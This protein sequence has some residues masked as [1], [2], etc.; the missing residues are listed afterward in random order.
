M[1]NRLTVTEGIYHMGHDV[2]TSGTYATFSR[3]LEGNDQP[4]IRRLTVGR[5]WQPVDFGWIGERVGMLSISNEEG[6]FLQRNPTEE[7]KKAL[8]AMVIEVTVSGDAD[9]LIL[10]GETM[11]GT[12]AKKNIR[13]RCQGGDAKVVVTVIPW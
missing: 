1:A 8:A 7:E 13:V 11:R 5:D 2:P 3:Q 6:K 12:P 10:P 9:W 4:Y